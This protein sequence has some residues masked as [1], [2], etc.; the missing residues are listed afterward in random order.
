MLLLHQPC[1][2]LVLNLHEFVS[3]AAQHGIMLHAVKAS[4]GFRCSCVV[5]ASLGTGQLQVDAFFGRW[6]EER[7]IWN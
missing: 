1:I 3:L 5:C 7:K 2:N 4:L 6:E